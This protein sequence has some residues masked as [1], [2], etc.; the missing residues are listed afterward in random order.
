M[1]YCYPSF[2]E[3]DKNRLSSLLIKGL[4]IF[5]YA[6]FGSGKTTLV[7]SLISDIN[8]AAYVDCTL[9][10]TVNSILRDV[11]GQYFFSSFM[12]DSL[13]LNPMFLSMRKYRGALSRSLAMGPS[14][15]RKT[16]RN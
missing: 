10:Q 15:H 4:N 16:G 11:L 3:D 5:I 9:N 8:N 7:K 6:P 14:A 12:N 13:Q 2:R 1:Q